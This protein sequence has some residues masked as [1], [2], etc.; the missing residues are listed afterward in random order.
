MRNV[1]H[2]L[3]LAR[4]GKVV[5]HVNEGI[6]KGAFKADPNLEQ[7]VS[8]EV[9][10]HPTRWDN[11]ILKK[12]SPLRPIFSYLTMRL[13]EDGVIRR[14][15]FKWEGPGIPANPESDAMVSLAT[16][17]PTPFAICHRLIVILT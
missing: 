14:L 12:N 10:R 13:R 1:Q 7:R 8:M 3:E 11:I 5:I 16:S 15:K 4:E 6:L 9:E 2:G 17:N